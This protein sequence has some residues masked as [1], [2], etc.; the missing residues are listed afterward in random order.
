M[1]NMLSE[2]WENTYACAEHYRCATAL[3]LMSMLSQAFS[4]IIDRGISAPG[5]VTE[6]VYGLNSIYKRF[7]FQLMSKVQLPCANIYDTKMV[8]HTGTRTSDG[9]FASEIQKHLST[10]AYKHGVINNRK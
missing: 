8:M 5:H 9:I 2:I 3:Y 10:A 1:L 4:V 7:I 6:V